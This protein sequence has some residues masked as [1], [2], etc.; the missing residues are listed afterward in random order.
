VATLAAVLA[1]EG[2]ID[3]NA[4]V[5][6]YLPELGS[7]GFGD[8]TVRQLLD[9]TTG[10]DYVEDYTD[11]QSS[12]WSLSRAGGFRPRPPGYAGPETFYEYMQTVQRATAHGERFAYKTVNTDALAWILRRVTGVTLSD[13]MH[14]RFWTR[15]GVE[16]D[17]YFSVDSC[18][19]EFAG[20]GLNLTLRDLVRF[21]EM[22]R[23]GGRFNGQQIVPEAVINDIRNG[24]N[25]DHFA[26][27]GYTLLPRWSYRTMWWVTHNEHGAYT[28]RGIHGQAI[29]IDPAA[30]MVIGRFA[31]HP[32]A[33]NVNLDPT[34]LPAYD[35]LARHL[36]RHS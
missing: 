22:M 6:Q 13:L 27:A 34:S 5:S 1:H 23:L 31:S 8:A 20:G 15:L 28:A 3:E 36:I 4:N 35:A 29:Y 10:I 17:A 33:A 21:G 2:L 16:Q 12:I 9:M 30:D 11:E 24:G 7:S 19:V 26:L 32:Q 18:G 14:E 25:R